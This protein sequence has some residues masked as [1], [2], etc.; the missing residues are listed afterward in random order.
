MR[1]QSI[2]LSGVLVWA[3]GCQIEPSHPQPSGEIQLSEEHQAAVDRRRELVLN[4]DVM[5]VDPQPGQ[6]A[7]KLAHSRLAFADDPEIRFDS[8]WWNW[9]EGNVVPYP[10]EILP[11]YNH[12]GFQYWIDN[13][14][15]LVG[16][17]LEETHSREIEGFFSMR[18]NGSDNDPQYV[19]GLGTIMDTIVQGESESPGGDVGRGASGKEVGKVP[20]VYRIPFKEENP[21][22]L[23]HTWGE[24]GYWNYAEEGVRQYYLR[25][26]REVTDRYDFDGIEL[27]FARGF[28][29]PPGE[30]WLQRHHMTDFLRQLRQMLLEV[31]ARRGKPFLLAAR[32]PE[33]LMGCHFDGLDVET[34]AREQLVDIFVLGCRSFE[35]DLDAFR[36]ITA[37]RNI[38]LYPALDHHHAADG[39]C[40]PPIEV[41]RGVVSNWRRQGANGL[42]TFNFAYGPRGEDEPWWT[43]HQ[44]FYREINSSDGFETLD[45]TFVAQRHGGGHGPIVHPNP[46][47]WS[48]PRH[49]YA[50]TNMLSIL[51]APLDAQGKT[52][53][54]LPVY[55]GDDV[56]EQAE[57]VKDVELWV[58]LHDSQL[59]DYLNVSR[60]DRPPAAGAGRIE[61]TVIRD[62]FIPERKEKANQPFLYNAP[63]RQG[64]EKKV[65]VRVNNTLLETAEVREG[66]LVFPVAPE[67]CAEGENLVGVR[68]TDRSPIAGPLLVE[69]LELRVRYHQP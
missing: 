7:R 37:G 18:M 9:G 47:D 42:Q 49:G 32:V 10:S 41:F 6:D 25:N 26:L 24:N 23:F 60:Y 15:D 19:P 46:E 56:N 38:K 55:V 61:R 28:V 57:K 51:P 5:I 53:L 21:E 29:F 45:K 11:R 2:L 35:V 14:I 27:D 66:W 1:T 64:I 31:E 68:V 50:N 12:P 4:F 54:L 8:I 43:M 22:W 48:T 62:W 30:A 59:G 40:T 67:Q 16:I 3:V 20:K 52:D 58:L 33:N 65:K 13:D 34:W 44:Q 36:R 63:P 39:Y 69:K 17:F